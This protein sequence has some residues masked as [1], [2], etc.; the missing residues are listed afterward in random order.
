M[1]FYI[2]IENVGYSASLAKTANVKTEE[3]AGL[4]NSQVAFTCVLLS[5]QLFV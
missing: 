4:I 3:C 1:L 5:K 2:E